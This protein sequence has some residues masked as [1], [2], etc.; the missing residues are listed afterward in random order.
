MLIIRNFDS[1]EGHS[2]NIKDGW[3]KVECVRNSEVRNR[4]NAHSL[5]ITRH[6]IGG[7]IIRRYWSAIYCFETGTPGAYEVVVYNT[8]GF[9]TLTGNPIS[10]ADINCAVLLTPDSLM[11]YI[12]NIIISNE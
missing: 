9:G 11:R 3:V 6:D 7:A 12:S 5:Y 2:T 8:D 10:R 4:I 1:I